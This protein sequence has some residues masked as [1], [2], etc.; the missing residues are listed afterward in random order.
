MALLNA[1]CTGY[2]YFKDPSILFTDTLR[3][4]FTAALSNKNN[5]SNNKKME[6][7][8][9]LQSAENY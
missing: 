6:K 5:N 3:F 1:H 9:I 7:S 2:W 8:G 4:N